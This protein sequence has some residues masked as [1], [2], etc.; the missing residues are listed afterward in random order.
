MNLHAEFFEAFFEA[1]C[2]SYFKN[3][4]TTVKQA[5]NFTATKLPPLNYHHDKP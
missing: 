4:L 3:I 1:F 2:K 5:F